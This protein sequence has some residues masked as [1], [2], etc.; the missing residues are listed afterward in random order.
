MNDEILALVKKMGIDTGRDFTVNNT[1]FEIINGIV[2]T[3][4]YSHAGSEKQ[5]FEY[6]DG[7]LARAYEQNLMYG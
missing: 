3:K 7:L 6:L 5:G 2:Q 4:G 1:T